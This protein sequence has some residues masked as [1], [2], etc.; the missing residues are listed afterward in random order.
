METIKI[1]VP[2]TVE[3]AAMC[4]LFIENVRGVRNG[5][6]TFTFDYDGVLKLIKRDTLTYK[7]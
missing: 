3:E 1:S 5:N 4:A 7:R 2:L 6:V